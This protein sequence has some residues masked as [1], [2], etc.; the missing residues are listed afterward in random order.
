[1]EHGGGGG[2]PSD[3]ERQHSVVETLDLPDLVVQLDRLE[4]KQVREGSLPRRE[5]VV[6]AA[7]E[8]RILKFVSGPAPDSERRET[9]RV[10]C[11]LDVSIVVGGG[12]RRA[13]A[14]DLGPGGIFLTARVDAKTGDAVEIQVPTSDTEHPLRVRGRVAWIRRAD[15]PGI[16]VSF[17]QLQSDADL[18]RLWRLIIQLLHAR[19][20]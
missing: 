8:R 13:H 19:V 11:Q 4:E 7:I 18:R 16:G 12:A 6:R 1:M 9:M 17:E 3:T 14:T 2:K 10:P 15:P 20:G 5:A